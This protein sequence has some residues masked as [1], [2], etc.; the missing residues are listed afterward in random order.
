MAFN[1]L[2]MRFADIDPEKI[3]TFPRFFPIFLKNIRDLGDLGRVSSSDKLRSG[4]EAKGV[5]QKTRPSFEEAGF[6]DGAAY[7]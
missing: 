6:S 1:G 2:F 7:A 3:Q 4:G 5:K